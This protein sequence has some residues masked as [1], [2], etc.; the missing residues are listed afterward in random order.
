MTDDSFHDGGNG[1]AAM[2]A[3]IDSLVD[4][5][6]GAVTSPP[7]RCDALSPVLSPTS[8]TSDTEQTTGILITLTKVSFSK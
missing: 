5:T 1:S 2:G 8:P 7:N 4:S 3:G 6:A